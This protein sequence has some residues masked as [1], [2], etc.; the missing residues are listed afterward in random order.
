MR[1]VASKIQ[2]VI[3]LLVSVC[4]KQ[5]SS[6]KPVTPVRLAPILLVTRAAF[7]ATAP[8]MVQHRQHAIMEV[9]HVHVSPHGVETSVINV[10]LRSYNLYLQ[11]VPYQSAPLAAVI[12]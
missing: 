1:W 2:L 6:G 9:V 4:A 7:R 10:L 11:S 12:W 3:L 5:M 8:H